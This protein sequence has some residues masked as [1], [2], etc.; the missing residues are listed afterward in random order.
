MNKHFFE[1]PA[2]A[3]ELIW[4]ALLIRWKVQRGK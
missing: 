2:A 3:R 1:L 4:K